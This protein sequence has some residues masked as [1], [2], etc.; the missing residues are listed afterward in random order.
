MDK[1]RIDRVKKLIKEEVSLIIQNKMKDPRIGFVTVTD[2]ELSKDLKQAQIFLSVMGTQKEKDDTMKALK[3]A[4][5]FVWE[6]LR[7]SIQIKYM[8]KI[9]FVM[10]DSL[11]RGSRVL[12]LLNEIKDEK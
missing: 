12:S 10:D 7:K 6:I 8:P 11:E 4:E 5:G 9:S 2:I 1:Y 3:G